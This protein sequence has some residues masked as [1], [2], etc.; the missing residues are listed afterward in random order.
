M[1]PDMNN[2]LPLPST[3]TVQAA[4]ALALLPA[5][6]LQRGRRALMRAGSG[7]ELL[8]ARHVYDGG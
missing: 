1:P 5:R 7:G 6:A 8:I 4:Y 2:K 3:A